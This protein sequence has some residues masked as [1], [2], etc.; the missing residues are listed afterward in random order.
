[1]YNDTTNVMFLKI[2]FYLFKHKQNQKQKRNLRISSKKKTFIVKP[3]ELKYFENPLLKNIL[4]GSQKKKN[5][6]LFLA[7][8]VLI[9]GVRFF[10]F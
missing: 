5:L 9:I 3:I 8:V 4:V 10:L 1:M 7:K 6:Q 2:Q